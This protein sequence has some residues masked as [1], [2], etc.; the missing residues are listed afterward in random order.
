MADSDFIPYP[1]VDDDAFYRVTFNKRE[2]RNTLVPS[3]LYDDVEDEHARR[4]FA[5][6]PH[7][8]FIRNFIAPH[9][10]YNS[11]LLFYGTGTG[12]TN[13]ALA[14]AEGHMAFLERNKK[15]VYILTPNET[16][17]DNFLRALYDPR[18]E[19]LE[20]EDGVPAGSYRMTGDTYNRENYK[21]LIRKRYC[22]MGYRRFS[23]Y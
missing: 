11:A 22:F 10:P 3:S 4:L 13:G 15:L 6:Q 20:E 19:R 7:Q 18:M 9:T 5:L 21:E 1:D 12:K 2:F 8:E 14:V 16:V 23:N 17:R